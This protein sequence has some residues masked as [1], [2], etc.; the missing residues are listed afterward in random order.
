MPVLVGT[1]GWQY[2]DWRGHFYPRTCRSGCGWSTTQLSP[3]TWCTTASTACFFGGYDIDILQMNALWQ[4]ENS[5]G[6]TTASNAYAIT[7]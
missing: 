1:S 2:D 5:F 6:P 3:R 4:T 7:A